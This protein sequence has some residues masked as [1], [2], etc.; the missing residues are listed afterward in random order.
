MI[1]DYSTS[2]L[3]IIQNHKGDIGY[4]RCL[5]NVIDFKDVE[6]DTADTSTQSA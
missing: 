5:N 3:G 2:D 4:I 6:R 1:L